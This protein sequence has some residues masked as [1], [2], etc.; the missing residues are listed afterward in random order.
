MLPR[1]TLGAFDLTQ[2]KM[3]DEAAAVDFGRDDAPQAPIEA[4]VQMAF[5]REPLCLAVIT[6]N[7]NANV[8]MYIANLLNDE[9]HPAVPVTAQ[10]LEMET[11]P[12]GG[13][14]STPTFIE[15]FMAFGFKELH[16]F[17][18]PRFKLTA[19][20]AIT[21]YVHFNGQKYLLLVT[22]GSYKLAAYR[23]HVNGLQS[24]D[25]YGYDMP[26]QTNHRVVRVDSRG[27]V[28]D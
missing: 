4:A 25:V 5:E 8:V 12:T 16:G 9:L 14:R 26:D 1:L 3:G 28:I 17:P 7:K 24:M 23:T 20:P 27:R 2:N 6:R 19:A 22:L 13:T 15:N 18:R 21:W 10:W 11:D